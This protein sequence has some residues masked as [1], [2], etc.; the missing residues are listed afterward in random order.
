MD[1]DGKLVRLK[2]MPENDVGVEVA[3][4][5]HDYGDGMLMVRVI[6]QYR[7]DQY[8]DGIR[9]CDSNQVDAVLE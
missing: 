6:P 3:Q 5:L 1:Y 2:P 4:V 8:D 9:E 7:V